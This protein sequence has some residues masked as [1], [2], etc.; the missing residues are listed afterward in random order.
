MQE[1][2]T[3][4]RQLHLDRAELV[5]EEHPRE[6]LSLLGVHGF[7]V[8]GDAEL[9]GRR[10]VPSRVAIVGGHDAEK[11]L[12]H[13]GVALHVA[14]DPVQRIHHARKIRPETQLRDAVRHVEHLGLERHEVVH[15]HAAVLKALARREV[16]VTRHLVHLK[17]P[18]YVAPLAAPRPELLAESLALA[19]L[20]PLRIA[21]RPSLEAIRLAHLLAGV[22][23]LLGGR[24]GAVAAA[25]LP[26]RLRHLA[27]ET[28]LLVARLGGVLRARQRLGA[29]LGVHSVCLAVDVLLASAVDGR[30]GG[31][32]ATL[33]DV[34]M[35]VEVLLAADVHH[36]QAHDVA[37]HARERDVEIDPHRLP[38]A[39]VHRELVVRAHGEV[40]AELG[41]EEHQHDSG[42]HE[43][44]HTARQ[45]ALE[46]VLVHLGEGVEALQ[47]LHEGR[48][49][50]GVAGTPPSA[51]RSQESRA[52]V[53]SCRRRGW[54]GRKSSCVYQ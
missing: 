27:L 44:D 2:S 46:E 6:I 12:V 26:Q 5:E 53:C 23:A 52:G 32:E 20:D 7:E 42:R 15:V 45:S 38:A 43:R 41:D 30:A 9:I 19:L 22:A 8:I 13:P 48:P 49:A 4:L 1:R 24:L 40:G 21:E 39:G 25:A 31:R 16:K 34:V 51:H 10:R 47:R 18:V 28:V 3:T 17:V 36:V 29:L 33:E 50:S 35:H 37:G 11:V 14:D 54:K